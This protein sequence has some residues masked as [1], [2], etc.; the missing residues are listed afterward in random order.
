MKLEL[1]HQVFVKSSYMEFFR[2]LTSSV[3]AATRLQAEG[4]T[5]CQYNTLLFMP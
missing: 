1:G 5:C 2:N 3:V 4:W